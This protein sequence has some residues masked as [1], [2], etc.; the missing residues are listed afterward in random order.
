[1]RYTLVLFHLQMRRPVCG[2]LRSTLHEVLL[3]LVEDLMYSKKENPAHKRVLPLQNFM[4]LVGLA[5]E[6][7][8]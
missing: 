4:A 2:H 3:L 6:T 1:M 8:L 5:E 7:R